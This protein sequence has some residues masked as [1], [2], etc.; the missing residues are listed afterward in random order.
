MFGHS[1]I[2]YSRRLN[3]SLSD[4]I[5]PALG[6]GFGLE[7]KVMFS[8]RKEWNLNLVVKEPLD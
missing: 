8:T 2:N 1:T 6:V 7:F 4:Y 5:T 3:G